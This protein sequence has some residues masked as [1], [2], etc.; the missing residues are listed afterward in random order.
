MKEPFSAD[1]MAGVHSDIPL[2]QTKSLDKLKHKLARWSRLHTLTPASPSNNKLDA[3]PCVEDISS[4]RVSPLPLFASTSSFPSVTTTTRPQ[5]FGGKDRLPWRRSHTH[6]CIPTM[7]ENHTRRRS[8]PYPSTEPVP[9]YPVSSEDRKA[10]ERPTTPGM[11]RAVPPP[12]INIPLFKNVIIPTL[13]I[14]KR[15]HSRS[16]SMEVDNIEDARPQ[17]PGN[18]RNLRHKSSRLRRVLSEDEVSLQSLP[19]PLTLSPQTP[20]GMKSIPVGKIS[21]PPRLNEGDLFKSKTKDAA[22]RDYAPPPSPPSEIEPEPNVKV[23]PSSIRFLASEAVTM[24]EK[25]RPFAQVSISDTAVGPYHIL[26]SLG[27]GSFSTVKLA[28]DSRPTP[29]GQRQMVA[30]KMVN[31][32]GIEASERMKASV[33][34]EM[35]LLEYIHHKRVVH[36]IDKLEGPEHLVLV[37]EYVTGGE[38]F[39]LVVSHPSGLPESLARSLFARLVSAVLYLH[40]H[41]IVHRDLKLENV[42]LTARPSESENIDIKLTDFGLG[43]FIDPSNPML[44]TRCGSEEYAAPELILGRPYDARLTDSWSLGVIL[45]ALLVGRLPFNPPSATPTT[46]QSATGYGD[47]KRALLHRIARAEFSFPDEANISREARGLVRGI[48]HPVP[49]KRLT[50]E[51]MWQHPWVREERLELE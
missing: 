7:A 27:T 3:F 6:S 50:V 13:S 45:Y 32:S 36:L 43:R 25:A 34:R 51:G 20:S 46:P 39:D 14:V 8:S 18:G 12:R 41:N 38:L 42:L 33:M 11:H 9:S 2:D 31:K 19:S 30:L 5:H 24:D 10:E 28:V 48:L 4:D 17:L 16:K 29:Y 22:Q 37:L 40:R 47:T 15:N 23:E 1:Q 26:K 44:E 35:E 49:A 21:L